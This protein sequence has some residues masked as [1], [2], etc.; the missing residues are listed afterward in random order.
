MDSSAQDRVVFWGLANE[1]F[2]NSPIFGIGYEMAWMAT[3]KGQALHNAFVTCYTELGLFGYWFWF[4]LIQLGVVGAI[5]T[6]AALRRVAHPEARALHFLA[7]QTIVALMGFCASAYFL[8]RTFIFPL[9]FLMA[10]LAAM[11]RV[12]RRFLPPHHPPL[13]EK[14]RDVYIWGTIGVLI[15]VAYIYVSIVILNKAYYG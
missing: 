5:R 9:F 12:A 1:L 14:R 11:P 7:G 2:K 10:M 4:L 15:S 13:M 8:S 3:Q 6:R